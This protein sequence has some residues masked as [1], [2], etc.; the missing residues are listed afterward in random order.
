MPIFFDFRPF[1]FAALNGC[2]V[3]AALCPLWWRRFCRAV[4]I[5]GL[6]ASCM[7]FRSWRGPPPC[8]WNSHVLIAICAASGGRD[9]IPHEAGGLAICCLLPRGV[10]CHRFGSALELRAA[11]NAAL[12]GLATSLP[13]CH[14][15]CS[16]SRAI[17]L[18]GPPE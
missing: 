14:A 8:V 13:S 9:K 5:F 7:L 18:V 16:P 1:A 15:Q 3:F 17:V 11:S 2:L 6:P 10:D 12:T 4:L